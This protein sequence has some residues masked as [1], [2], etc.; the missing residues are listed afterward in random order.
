MD[1]LGS[2]SHSAKYRNNPG[3]GAWINLIAKLHAGVQKKILNL[4]MSFYKVW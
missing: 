1:H 2:C 4:F 3:K